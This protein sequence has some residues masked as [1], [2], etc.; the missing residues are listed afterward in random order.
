MKFAV[1]M[2]CHNREGM[3]IE[4]LRGLYECKLHR[5]KTFDVWLN[6]DGC[7]DGTAAKVS[8]LFP[9]VNVIMGS[10]HDYWCGGMRRAWGAASKYFDYDGYVWLNDDT[11]LNEDAF[12]VMFEDADRY[13]RGIVVG[14]IVG[15]D[16]KTATYGGEDENGFIVPDGTW[17]RLRQMNGNAV[18][19]P[20]SAF[21]RLGNF[22]PYLT[23]A[24]GDCDYSRSAVRAG[25]PVWLT[26][27]CIGLC[28]RHPTA[29][30]WKRSDVP[31]LKR[32][33]SLY[34]PL[35]GCEPLVLFRYCLKHDGIIVALKLFVGNHL[36]V[37]FP[38][39]WQ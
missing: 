20:R 26:P 33:R 2:T 1:I 5:G 27:R 15:H 7:T 38:R 6:D 35:G 30:A 13:E 10:G 36:R 29:D 19:I 32:I 12:Q 9:S 11:F 37:F 31:L 39:R 28:D 17:R 24:L 14:S 4:C 16:G 18:W 21:R 22:E 25:I 3:T 8:L 34:S 23:H